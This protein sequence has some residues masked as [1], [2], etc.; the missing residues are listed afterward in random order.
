MPFSERLRE[1]LPDADEET[2]H[3]I[4]LAVDEEIVLAWDNGYSIGLEE[5]EAN[6]N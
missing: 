1:L 2:L 4:E 6:A 5:G 3:Q